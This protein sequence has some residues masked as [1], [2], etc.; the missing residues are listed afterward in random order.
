MDQ[1]RWQADQSNLHFFFMKSH[2]LD[3]EFLSFK[4]PKL[5]SYSGEKDTEAAISF[6]YLLR[7]FPILGCLVAMKSNFPIIF[8]TIFKRFSWK[9]DGLTLHS[10]ISQFLV[11]LGLGQNPIS[12]WIQKTVEIEFGVDSKCALE[13]EGGKLKVESTSQVVQEWLVSLS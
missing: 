13:E 8:L 10:F 2:P 5:A 6:G 11:Y 4:N 7:S 9:N 1:S 12:S 3:Q